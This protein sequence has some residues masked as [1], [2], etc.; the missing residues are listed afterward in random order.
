[1]SVDQ[2]FLPQHIAIVMDGNGR[3]AKNRHLPRFL[4]HRK[5]VEAARK[6]VNFCGLYGIPYLTLFAFSTENWNRPDEE[7][8]QLM[9]L[10]LDGLHKET[11]KL[12]KKGVKILFVGDSSRIS[13][14]LRKRMDDSMK[15][16]KGNTKM[17][18][19]ICV[20]Y[21]GKWDIVQAANAAFKE[22]RN[23]AITED[24]LQA[25]LSTGEIPNPDLF[26]RTSGEQRISNF[27]LWQ[28]AYSEL[29]FTPTLW[30]DF[31]KKSLDEALEIYAHRER[32]FGSVC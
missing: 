29:F 20:D 10:F 9:T 5:G 13:C 8:S 31:D 22:S 18:L 16:T 21:G 17:V 25:Q 19:S 1:M 32:R 4:G 30:P 2:Q 7:V 11:P 6:V 3:W 23:T 27:L 14:E 26:I 12:H 28:L 24:Q 15:L